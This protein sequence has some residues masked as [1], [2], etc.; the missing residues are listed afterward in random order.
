MKL[1]KVE[2]QTKTRVAVNCS[3]GRGAKIG[4]FVS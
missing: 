1:V 4:P 3:R 2:G